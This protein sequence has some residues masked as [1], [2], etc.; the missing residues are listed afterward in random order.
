MSKLN[1]FEKILLN[2][3]VTSLSKNIEYK[4]K[5]P[6]TWLPLDYISFMYNTGIA[7]FYWKF[8]NCMNKVEDGSYSSDGFRI[9]A[10]DISRT[11]AIENNFLTHKCKVHKNEKHSNLQI[12]VNV[13]TATWM[14]PFS[15]KKDAQSQIPHRYR[16][17]GL[18]VPVTFSTDLDQGIIDVLRLGYRA[19]IW[20]TELSMFK[21]EYR[22]K[23]IFPDNYINV[24]LNEKSDRVK[25]ITLAIDFDATRDESGSRRDI[26]QEGD[27]ILENTQ[28]IINIV[29]NY[30]YEKGITDFEWWFSGGGIYLVMHHTVCAEQYKDIYTNRQY[31]NLMFYKWNKFKLEVKN[32]LEKEK[33]MYIGVD[34]GLQYIRYYIKG[35]FSLHRKYD[36]TT[37]P[38]TGMFGD[39]EKIDLLT[40]NWRHYIDP[41]NITRDFVEKMNIEI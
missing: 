32:L 8:Y 16:K 13:P 29:T 1:N 38:L 35:P 41:R 22:G 17:D 39:N 23:S 3:G 37:L 36:R 5:E 24:D 10:I 12:D 21:N 31:Y 28:K 34:D 25:A 9:P 19:R 27:K 20:H 6:K 2:E 11:W 40:S 7:E 33:V 4:T 30:L 26:L 15:T 14:C 18:Y